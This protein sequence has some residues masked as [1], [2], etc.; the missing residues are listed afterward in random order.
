MLEINLLALFLAGLL[1][2]GHC[3]GMCGGIVSA[4]SLQLPSGARWPYLLGFNAGRLLGYVLIGAFLGGVGSFATLGSLQTIKIYLFVIA[5]I[6]LIMLGLYI[7]GWSRALTRIEKIGQPIWR[8]VQPVMRKLLPVHSVWQTPLIGL[9]WG[10]IPCGLVYTAS[11]SALA[12]ASPVS[13]AGVMLAFG[14]GTLPNLM[15]MGLLAKRV[16]SLVQKSWVRRLCG[17][18]VIAMASYQLFLLMGILL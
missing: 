18:V 8:A 17:L 5:N 1:G 14:L 15:L 13:G 10:W 7:A 11:L 12:S 6:L 16:Q 4:F 2:G 3:I 9:L